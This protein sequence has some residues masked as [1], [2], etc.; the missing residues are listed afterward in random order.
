MLIRLLTACLFLCLI[1]ATTQAQAPDIAIDEAQV[2][3]VKGYPIGIFGNGFGAEQGKG[4]V[5]ILGAEARI[6]KWSDTV[7]EAIV[8]DVQP[9]VGQLVVAA[10]NG[11]KA[12]GPFEVYVIDPKFLTHPADLVN[13]AD[14]KKFVITGQHNDWA[15]NP[16]DF[17]GYCVNRGANMMPPL[18]AAVDL[19]SAITDDVW[20]YIY[21]G[22][23]YYVGGDIPANY[24]IDASA[25][26]KDGTDGTWNTLAT[27]TGNDHKSRIHKVTLAG[28]RW[29]RLNVSAMN[30]DP[31]VKF[32][33]IS[34][35]R[36]Y[37]RKS[38]ATGPI[39]CIG[40]M[41]DSITF[42]DLGPTGPG[43][44]HEL[45]AKGKNNG[46][47]PAV[48]VMGLIGAGNG[49]LSKNAKP[50]RYSLANAIKLHPDMRYFGI[51]FG[52]N[53]SNNPAFLP[54]YTKNMC[55][56]VEQ[57]IEA[58]KVPILARLPD[59]DNTRRGYGS[60]ATKKQAVRATDEVAAKY[61]L[62]PGPDFYTPFRQDLKGLVSDGT[63]HTAKGGAVE[64]QLWADVFLRSGIYGDAASRPASA[65]AVP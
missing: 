56:G 3:G 36:V 9:A 64:R 1:T 22:S 20:F 6:T 30:P 27:I 52:T 55:D 37:Q 5:T 24:T 34:E 12:Q 40:I 7:I 18:A 61:R 21:G 58:G 44:L 39:D 11:A 17:L 54:T 26:S 62:I 47:T 14:K 43:T 32:F 42:A 63:H 25:D 41:G 38:P 31:K 65:P 33:R 35:I 59:T 45:I 15:G 57:L 60:P 49:G 13:L 51:A 19:G 48:Y 23:D 16:R 10:D 28:Q 29:I 2:A 4:K 46:S 50:D 53:D 8:P